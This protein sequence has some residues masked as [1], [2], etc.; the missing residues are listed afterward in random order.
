[1]KIFLLYLFSAFLIFSDRAS[2]QLISD[3]L[4]EARVRQGI[5]FVY[6]LSFDSATA[7][8]QAVVR[9][10]P[11]HPAGHF[12]LAMVEWWKIITNFSDKSR[13]EKFLTLLDKV[14]DL[15]DKRLD[16]DE[17]D[18]TGLFFKGGALGFQ[19]RLYGN[20]EDWLKAANCGR[21]ALPIV[22]KAS[23]LAPG[24]YDILLG[25][26]IYNYYAAVIPD[27]YPFVKPLMM[28]FPKGNKIKGIEQL[29]A[30]SQK[31]SYAN[32]EATYF[33]TQ[34]LQN[35]EKQYP[36]ALS[37]ALGLYRS[38]PNNA[39]FHKYAGRGYASAGSWDEMKKTYLEM[40]RRVNSGQRGYDA[41][42]ER[43]ANYYL[44]LCE[45][46]FN[47]NDAALSY[48]YRSDEISRTLD[49]GELSGFM[50]MTNL[51]IGM[52][53]DLQGKRDLAVMQYKK[54]LDMKDFAESHKL[55]EQYLKSPYQ[56]S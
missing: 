51:K 44:G 46:N 27:Q 28:F 30:A 8:F 12:F 7:E 18:L 2:A 14:I 47:N 33:L 24:N 38:F 43:E 40:L 53:Y 55:A 4:S 29:R 5:R 42:A 31:A 13:D 19:G 35:F 23:K 37:L 41:T 36:E 9:N 56:K 52:I 45:M 54:V 50:I 17:N 20:R 39:I 22:Q 11:E 10:S 3:S 16:K 6:N 25:T 49:I 34:I 1:M 32:F 15:C 21:V 26:G 48:F